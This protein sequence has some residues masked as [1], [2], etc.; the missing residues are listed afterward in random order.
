MLLVEI[1]Q[2][3]AWTTT[4]PTLNTMLLFLYW[5]GN[6]G[7]T[8]LWGEGK[9]ADQLL[10]M[11]TLLSLKFWSHQAICMYAVLVLCLFWSKSVHGTARWWQVP[12][13]CSYLCNVTRDTWHHNIDTTRHSQVGVRELKQWH[14]SVTR[15]RVDSSVNIMAT[16]RKCLTEPGNYL[17]KTYANANKGKFG[18][19]FRM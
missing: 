11:Y 1:P 5:L 8:L 14:L 2:Q 4:T 6:S 16:S 10:P 15:S 18:D 12:M 13:V 3:P 17:D 7:Y 19:I 9:V